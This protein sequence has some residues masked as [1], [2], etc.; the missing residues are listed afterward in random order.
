MII[1][2][3]NNFEMNLIQSIQVIENSKVMQIT[4]H[5]HDNFDRIFHST[6]KI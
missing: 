5:D 2:N 6:Q 1:N 4:D 3:I